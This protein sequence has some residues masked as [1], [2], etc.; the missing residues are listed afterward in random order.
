MTTRHCLS[1]SIKR[2]LFAVATVATLSSA[3]AAAQ[4]RYHVTRIG[5]FDGTWKENDPRGMNNAGHVVGFSYAD[6]EN[7]IPWA[8]I[9]TGGE[10]TPLNP[11]PGDSYSDAYAIN[12][13]GQVVGQSFGEFGVRIVAW[14]GGGA[15]AVLP[16]LP[17]TIWS[18]P[19]AINNNGQIVGQTYSEA[20]GTRPI[21]WDNG[22]PRKLELLP[23]DTDGVAHDINN[24]GEI[25]GNSGGI[26][27][28]WRAGQLTALGTLPDTLWSWA[29]AIND[30]G[31]VVGLC[32]GW[33]P[34]ARAFIWQDGEMAE[35]PG[36]APQVQTLAL[37]VNASGVAIGTSDQRPVLWDAAGQVHDVN[38]LLA[39]QS[40]HWSIAGVIAI[41]DAGQI[42][43]Y[44]NTPTT[45]GTLLLTPVH[46]VPSDD[47]DGTPL[48]NSGLQPL[49]RP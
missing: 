26:A 14:Q 16:E 25:A 8:Y 37:D 7:N 27:V 24:F 30:A 13:L 2:S 18:Y 20:L 11:L 32:D 28:V 42:V 41:N 47:D 23:G 12:D 40:S 45:A 34:W 33:N 39:P 46:S 29:S 17:G 5:T 44:G 31:Q 49:P 15:A 10:L 9:W 19:F 38:D 22:V 6:G 4:T 48:A 21:L 36:L 43:G 3:L 35:L 1:L